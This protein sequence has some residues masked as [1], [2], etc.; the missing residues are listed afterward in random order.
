MFLFSSDKC[1]GVELP[2][3]TVVLFLIFFRSLCIV[4]HSGCTKFV[5][6]SNST[7][8]S[9]L[10]YILTNTCFLTIAILISVSWYLMVAL[11]C[12]SLMIVILR[13]FSCTCWPSVYLLWGKKKCLFS[14]STHF[15]ISLSVWYWLVHILC[16]I[17]F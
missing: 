3:Y 12:I 9:P 13:I 11:I 2:H 17:G 8:A 10:L 4:F 15:L 6:P 7:L 1:I 5:Y 16:T 14:S